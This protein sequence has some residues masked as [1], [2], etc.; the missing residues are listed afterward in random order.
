VI[1]TV[2]DLVGVNSSNAQLA[3]NTA[4]FTGTVLF[5]PVPPPQY[6]IGWQSLAAGTDALCTSD[7]SVALTAP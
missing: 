5:S 3:W 2:V 4:G 7:I 6:K 1:C